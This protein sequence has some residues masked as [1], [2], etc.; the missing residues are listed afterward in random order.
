VERL[1]TAKVKLLLSVF[2]TAA[3]G[4]L[5]YLL[6]PPGELKTFFKHISPAGFAVAFLLYALSYLF[7]TLRWK[8]Y[9]PT[10]PVG[11]LFLT[12]AVNTFL[13]NT[14]P[15]RLG[16]LSVFG[17]L[18]RFDPDVKTT[19]K[20]F[21]KVRLYDGIALLTVLSFA[22]FYIKTNAAAA[23]A[24]AA[25]VYPLF[26]LLSRYTPKIPA[27]SFEPKTFLL[28]LGALLS[29]LLAVYTVLEFLK[30]D[31]WRFAIG[32]LGGEIASILP[33]NAFANLGTYE[34]SF[35][36]ALKFLTGES[37]KDGV[38]IAFMSHL[39]LLLS[40]AVLGLISLPFVFKRV[41]KL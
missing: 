41:K 13:N 34:S 6:V 27:L 2:A 31:L 30:I 1:K 40:S 20:K 39:F 3:G 8:L 25:A 22:V 26:L 32:F 4:I 15:M 14:V 28:S 5:I 10:A 24:A 18:R 23:F 12:T 19:I 36:L 7:R 17:F 35:S 21:L 33:V 29:K 37:F 11:Y 9:Y 16:E 38:R